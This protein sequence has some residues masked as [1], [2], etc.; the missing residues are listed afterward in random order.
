[1]RVLTWRGW[2][3]LITVTV[4]IALVTM[5]ATLQVR[6]WLQDEAQLHQIVQLIQS[7][8]IRIYPNTSEKPPAPTPPGK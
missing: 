3:L 4:T 6:H 7:G 5:L 8:Q 2:L 1:M